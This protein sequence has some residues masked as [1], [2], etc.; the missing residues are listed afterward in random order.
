MADKKMT[1]QEL[2]KASGGGDRQLIIQRL[3]AVMGEADAEKVTN[4]KLTA[5][6]LIRVLAAGSTAVASAL[7]ASGIQVMPLSAPP[8]EPYLPRRDRETA[9]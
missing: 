4:S 5:A 6:E 2:S 3:R 7:Q 9:H 8:T 1:P